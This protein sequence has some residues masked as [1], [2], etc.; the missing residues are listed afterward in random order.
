MWFQAPVSNIHRQGIAQFHKRFFTNLHN[1]T[2]QIEGWEVNTGHAN[3]STP[4][5]RDTIGFD[6]TLFEGYQMHHL[7]RYYSGNENWI[8]FSKLYEAYKDIEKYKD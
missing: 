6:L 1:V 4:L 8:V 2:H 5:E 3:I 7:E